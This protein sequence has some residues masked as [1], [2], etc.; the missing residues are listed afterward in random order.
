[1][2]TANS[3]E[4]IPSPLLNRMAVYEVPAPT[5]EQAAAIAQHIYRGLLQELNLGKFALRL[6]DADRILSRLGDDL[7]AQIHFAFLAQPGNQFRLPDIRLGSA[8]IRR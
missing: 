4:G 1:V 2:L 3:T 6:G 7:L 5:P 8:A